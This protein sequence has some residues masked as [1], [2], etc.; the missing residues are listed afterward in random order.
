MHAATTANPHTV[1]ISIPAP[2]A[3]KSIRF[4]RLLPVDTLYLFPPLAVSPVLASFMHA[5]TSYSIR[6]SQTVF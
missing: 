1:H 2:N 6:K 3:I 5:I 4:N